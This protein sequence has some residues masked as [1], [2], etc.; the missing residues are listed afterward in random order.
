MWPIIERFIQRPVLTLSF[1]ILILLLGLFGLM[2]LPVRLLPNLTLATIEI[3][4]SYPGANPSDVQAFVTNTL[5]SAIVGVTGVDYMTAESQPGESDINIILEPGQDPNVAM[6]MVMEKIQSVS[7]VLPLAVEMPQV[8]I[9]D[10]NHSPVM[11]LAFT[12]HRLSRVQVADYLRRVV[13]PQWEAIDGVSE[14]EVLGDQYAMQIWVNPL[15]LLSYQLTPSDILNALKTQN[16]LAMPGSTEGHTLNYNLSVTTAL[17]SADQFNQVIIKNVNGYPVR[18]EDI[19]KAS[20]GTRDDLVAVFYNHQQTTMI[21][22]FPLPTA[23]PLTIAKTITHKLMLLQKS[24]PADIEAHVVFSN[25]D[26]IQA[27][28][29]E[30]VKTLLEASLIVIL[31]MFLFLG[32]WR[33]VLIPMVTI[34]LSLIGICFVMSSL[35]YSLNIITFL[36]M[37]LAIGLVVD[38]AIVVVENS[39]RHIQKGLS[40]FAAT[41]QGTKELVSP[42]I[43]MTITLAAVYVPIGFSSG[44][45][46]QLFTEFALTLAGSVMVSGVIALS[47]SPMMAARLLNPQALNSKVAQ[48]S[49][50]A[51]EKLKSLYQHALH[52]SFQHTRWVIGIWLSS[53]VLISYMY[54]TL[55]AE[56]M[57]TDDMGYLFVQGQGPVNA[58]R[59][60]VMQ[61]VPAL[62]E[63][64]DKNPSID[65]VVTVVQGNQLF[66]F[67]IIKADGPTHVF[68]PNLVSGLQSS[69]NTIAGLK[70]Q[71]FPP[72]LLM[73]GSAPIQVVM[74]SAAD[75][76]ELYFWA[77]KIEEKA[78]ASR[79]FLF[80][81]DDLQF[82]QPEAEIIINP[83]AAAATN[84][85][86]DVIAQNLS[87]LMGQA[88]QQQ[89]SHQGQSYD[90]IIKTLPTYQLNPNDLQNIPI[91]TQKGAT[92][93]LSTIASIRYHVVPSSLHQFQKLHSVT[94]SGMTSPKMSVSEGL[95]SLTRLVENTSSH[96]AFVDYAG[97]SRQFIKEGHRMLW[98]FMLAILVIFLVLSMQFESFCDAL[99]ILVGSVPLTIMVALLP[100]KLGFGTINIYT[101]IALLTLVGLVSKH[102]ILITEFANH[103]KSINNESRKNAVMAA[104]MLRFRPIVM[105]TLAI[106][107]GSLPLIFASGAGAASRH[108]LGIVIEVGM[109]LGTCMTLLVFPVIYA[110]MPEKRKW[111]GTKK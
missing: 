56:L 98:I 88:R 13:K 78:M 3:K 109:W 49:E 36:A 71:V 53:F 55:P 97:Y 21:R 92:I 90:V 45:T 85:S 70:F 54:G 76:Q 86:M 100:L 42:I 22:L 62:F 96:S 91:V 87:L 19:G 64:Y 14:A 30:V 40:P 44:L 43:S 17:N 59:Q 39:V 110:E 79:D 1:S 25:A 105:T 57:P 81:T 20:I 26:F 48:W 32:T 7:H 108:A 12:S 84:V 77:K 68:A 34:P 52:F 75:Y 111:L 46:G 101:E 18:I 27:S 28:I 60:F 63:V 89:F 50:K 11:Y 93:P 41:L 31:V 67:P 94:L 9:Q 24:L 103:L 29:H 10:S 95:S 8:L 106:V 80:L 58:N 33:T 83:D 35:G 82:N 6:T 74:E 72:R 107:F 47:L 102:G 51:L 16:V 99:I 73:G 4:T 69:L 65:H 2:R 61:Y 37:V 23:N 5:Q 66:S 104:A 15:Q 38:D